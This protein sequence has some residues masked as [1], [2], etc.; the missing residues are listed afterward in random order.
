MLES[1]ETRNSQGSYM[2]ATKFID[3]DSLDD[4]LVS[5]YVDLT[6]HQLRAKLESE[7]GIMIVESKFAIER[8]LRSGIEPQSLLVAKE[9][10]DSC[11]GILDLVPESCP[12]LVMPR[13][14]MGELAGFKVTRG[15]LSS[16]A[17]PAEPAFDELIAHA[18][19]IAV[20]EGLVDTTNVGAVF[21]S[22]AAL[23]ADAVLLAPDCADVYARRSIRVSM[24]TVFQVPLAHIPSEMWPTAALTALKEAGFTCAAMALDERAQ[25]LAAFARTAPD[26]LALLF[27]NEGYGLSAEAIAACDATVMIPMANDVDSLNVAASSAVAFWSLFNR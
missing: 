8:A 21:R 17:R 19:H 1:M 4:D 6:D 9:K 18:R 27:G 7:R 14:A 26:K 2:T 20:L 16:M 22:A 11:A 13:D 3:V 10:L 24:G 23:G 12:V 5:D 15:V 25:D